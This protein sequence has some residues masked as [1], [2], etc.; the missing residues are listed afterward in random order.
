M[1]VNGR[2]VCDCMRGEE[3]SEEQVLEVMDRLEKRGNR[4]WRNEKE[5][6]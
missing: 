6:G 3:E 2:I 4:Y 1:I 5:R